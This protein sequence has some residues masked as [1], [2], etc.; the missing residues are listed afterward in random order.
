LSPSTRLIPE[1]PTPSLC[2]KFSPSQSE[3]ISSTS[4]TAALLRTEDKVTPFSGKPVLN[5]P[6]SHGEP[7]E[8]SQESLESLEVELPELVKPLSVTCA[9]RLECSLLSRSGENGIK[10]AMSLKEDMPLLL[11]S[12][13]LPAPHSS[14]P[15]DTKLMEFQSSH[16]SFRAKTPTPNLSSPLSTSLVP[17]LILPRSESPSKSDKELENI[18]TPDT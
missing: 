6:P 8:P 12:P 16:L 11:P 14:W 13:L 2:Q 1:S 4:F 15:E 7:V 17:E 18:E 10:N 3:T 5:T 9:E